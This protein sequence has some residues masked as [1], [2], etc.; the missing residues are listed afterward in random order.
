MDEL[1]DLMDLTA[2]AIT[3][4]D[5]SVSYLSLIQ[6]KNYLKSKLMDMGVSA[7]QHVG[8]IFSNPALFLYLYLALWEID[9]TIVPLDSQLSVG[10]LVEVSDL[11]DL[12]W[13]LSDVIKFNSDYSRL[14]NELNNNVN[15]IRLDIFDNTIE[16]IDSVCKCKNISKKNSTGIIILPTSGTLGKPKGVILRKQS[17]V[18]NFQKVVAYTRLSSNDKLLMTLPLSYSYGMSQTLSHLNVGGHVVF[19]RHS[20]TPSVI[21]SEIK[22]HAVTNY[23][24]TPYF[25]ES[26]CHQFN[27][28]LSDEVGDSF[29]FFMNAGGL[30]H[31][32]NIHK[33]IK[34]FPG[35]SF[36]NNYGQTEAGPRLAYAEFSADL[37]KKSQVSGVGKSLP[38]VVIKIINEKG[39]DAKV[40][41]TGQI[42]YLSEDF[43]VGYYNDHLVVK[44]DEGYFSSGDLGYIDPHGFLIVVGRSDSMLKINGRKVYLGAIE[45]C[46]H[47]ID[48]VVHVACIKEKHDTYGEY[49]SA[50][51]E[52]IK[53]D[54]TF[55][56]HNEI[57]KEI[58]MLL[59]SIERPKKIIFCEKIKILSNGKISKNDLLVNE[60]I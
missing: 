59:P 51:I 2:P 14:F 9:A 29:R 10:K 52:T 34:M 57:I 60:C 3:F 41:E 42:K 44:D 37:I 5:S 40:G 31:E 11:L 19:S 24:A 49:I 32:D 13:I 6:I 48:G 30:L 12:D 54:N 27:D 38:G 46:I 35:V 36:F 53:S 25:Y 17:I 26:V 56:L 16:V 28:R 1:I 45:N 21:F 58:K 39:V 7:G 18:N 8:L 43:M 47:R 15:I 4:E 33:I 55:N 50:Y 20:L 23:A 22:K